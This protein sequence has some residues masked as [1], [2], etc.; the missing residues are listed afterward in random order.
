MSHLKQ[1]S[2][3]IENFTKQQVSHLS[4][5]THP[6]QLPAELLGVVN[7]NGEVKIHGI[8][9]VNQPKTIE[10]FLIVGTGGT[11]PSELLARLYRVG[12]VLLSD[13]RF[14]YHVY[15]VGERRGIPAA[16]TDLGITPKFKLLLNLDDATDTN[17]DEVV[18]LIEH[19]TAF[20]VKHSG[21]VRLHLEKS[22]EGIIELFGFNNEFQHDQEFLNLVGYLYKADSV[23]DVNISKNV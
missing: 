21:L 23:S 5:D 3:V 12:T 6:F 22:H 11:V 15:H 16:G 2:F 14:G 17:D 8:V 13:N 9:D 4:I 18:A 19:L 20:C 7:Q 1:F 10:E